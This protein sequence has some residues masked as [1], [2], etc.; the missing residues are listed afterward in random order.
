MG[1]TPISF[2]GVSKF[3]ED[4]QVILERAFNIANLPIKNLHTEQTVLLARSQALSSLGVSVR[5]LQD[6]FSS[7]GLL[8][9]R[10]AISAT[11]SNTSVASVLVT[12]NPVPASYSLNVTSAASAAQESS[13]LGL[14]DSDASALRTDG[15]F[16][17]T[18]GGE[19]LNL[20]LLTIGSGRTA[21]TAGASTPSPKPSVQV[22]FSNGLSGS[23][24]AELN[25]FFVASSAP[26]G[27]TVGDTVSV[28]LVSED[29]TI[30]ETIT[31]DPLAGGEDAAAIATLLNNAIAA[32][33][34]LT[35]KVSFSDEGG[36]LKLV[37]SDTVGQ[38]FT[39]SSS[40]TGSIITGLESGGTIGGQSAQELAAALN[41]QVALNGSLAA[42]GVKFTAVNGEVKVSGGEAFD[43][44][45]TDDDQGT[46]FASGLAGSH[47]VAGFDNTLE[48]LRDAI[49]AQTSALGVKASIINT[50][51]NPA[52]PSY[53]LSLAATATGATTLSLKDSGAAELLTQV[54][55]GT[56]AVFALNGVPVTNSG[57]TISGFADGLSLTIQG[58][59]TSTVTVSTD[60]T[61]ISNALASIATAYNDL[62]TALQAHIGENAGVLSGDVAVRQTQQALRAIT[63]FLGSG[64]IGSAAALGLELSDK[65]QL[66]FNSLTF[67]KLSDSQISGALEFI[68]DTTSGFAGN[69]FNRLNDIANPVNGQIQAALNFLTKSDQR[70]SEQ[71]DAANERVDILVANLEKRFAAA[72]LLLAQLES[73]QTLL[74]RLFETQNESNRNR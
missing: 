6:S 56:D 34:N 18:I 51:S 42:A 4:F 35:G 58:A 2:A 69:A 46:G 49:N 24:T 38:G 48:G 5:A 19:T 7:L 59:G 26:S 3:S 62:V 57:N 73:Q 17:L 28:T 66:T 33:G 50:S 27:A 55:Q 21:G 71:I 67:A 63:G 8:G 29:G 13:L 70:L 72:D 65:G 39:F 61:S 11:S 64:T 1:L 14:P 45:V 10:Q 20:D 52:N 25:S 12:G 68:G 40:N 37:E 15:I 43:M 54:N 60:R 31:T 47:S 32:N 9:A 22:D 41:A 74:T 44:T 30:N 36:S 23:I 16:T 53:H